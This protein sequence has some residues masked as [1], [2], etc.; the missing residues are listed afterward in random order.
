[1]K[2]NNKKKNPRNSSIELLRI[3][4]MF[5]I[6]IHHY[7]L[8]GNFVFSETTFLNNV[9]LYLSIL[10]NIAVEIFVLISGYYL[11]TSDFKISKLLK[12]LFEITSY[13]LIIYIL[14]VITGKTQFSPTLLKHAMF[15]IIYDEYWFATTYV[16]LYLLS[17][18]LN[19]LI[20]TIE[21][22]Q[23]LNLLIIMSLLWI[24]IPSLTQQ[25]LYSS[26]VIEFVLLYFIGG[27]LKKYQDCYLLTNIKVT[28]LIT[29]SSIIFIIIRVI[30]NCYNGILDYSFLKRDSIFVITIAVGI[31]CIFSK[32]TFYN[33][34]IN[35]ISP[36]IFGI[37]LLHDNDYVRNLL[38]L[39][40]FKNSNYQT[41]KYLIFHMI[42]SVIIV[43]IIGLVIELFRNKFIQK[44]INKLFDNFEKKL[45]ND[46]NNK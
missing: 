7:S 21:R 31:F 38:W 42:A 23:H 4:L 8:Y 43:F 14:F 30:N 5:M 18:F 40:I 33:K 6:I 29:L 27:Y 39:E 20:N 2:E 13:S 32:K 19:K 36:C 9:I 34:T 25:T 16:I 41:S 35:K 15:P 17:P 26:P 10:G 46:V 28:K 1:M 12:L 44:P 37:Y 11:S 24:L 3:I 45:Q 22:K